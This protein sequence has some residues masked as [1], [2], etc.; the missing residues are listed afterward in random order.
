[1]ETTTLKRTVLGGLMAAGIF[2]LSAFLEQP[3]MQAAPA[4]ATGN[5]ALATAPVVSRSL[6]VYRSPTVDRQPELFKSHL[7]YRSP[8][9]DGRPALSSSN[10]LYRAPSANRAP[11]IS[12]RRHVY[13]SA[14]VF[15]AFT[16]SGHRLV[17]RA[18]GVFRAPTA[19]SRAFVS[20]N[21]LASGS[22]AS[23]FRTCR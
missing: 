2:G 11:S 14:A 15:G 17:Y 6:L 23:L 8:A 5:V 9:A 13:R 16:A 22:P 4:S 19:S 12:S 3:D 21:R 7:V 18:P 1:M 10:L 20:S